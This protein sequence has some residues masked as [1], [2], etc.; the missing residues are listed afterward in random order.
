MSFAERA[1]NKIDFASLM[2][3]VAQELLGEPNN[4][5]SKPPRDVRYGTHGSLSVDLE[6]GRFYDHEN[7]IGGGV[8]DLV[9]LKVRV[10][11]ND[12]VAWLTALSA[13]FPAVKASSNASAIRSINSM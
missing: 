5:L 1:E 8:I 9:K 7:S 10:D 4:I 3:A 6:N 12:A 13:G 2:P 11:H